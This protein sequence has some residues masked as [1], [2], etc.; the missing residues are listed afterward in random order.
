MELARELAGICDTLLKHHSSTDPDALDPDALETN[1]TMGAVKI[2]ELKEAHFGM[3]QATEELK[4]STTEAMN[5]LDESSLH[6]ENLL[7][8]KSHYERE[9]Q[10]CK[11]YK[12]AYTDEQLEL[13]AAEEYAAR[14]A[15][16][17]AKTL[18]LSED[19]HTAMLARLEEE[20][21]Y[22]EQ[23]LRDLEALKVKRDALAAQLA[24]RRDAI[25]GLQSDIANLRS[26]AQQMQQKY[27][28]VSNSI[29]KLPGPLYMLYS[30][31]AAMAALLDLP[32]T[33]SIVDSSRD[34]GE[35]PPGISTGQSHPCAVKFSFLLKTPGDP[36]DRGVDDNAMVEDGENSKEPFVIILRYFPHAHTVTINAKDE[37]H[38]HVL[39]QLFEKD[40]SLAE[41]GDSVNEWVVNNLLSLHLFP[42]P[43]PSLDPL[44]LDSIPCGPG[45]SLGAE[46]SLQTCLNILSF[47]QKLMS[48]I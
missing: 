4:Q 48:A 23:V 36:E 22:R 37:C 47:L 17:D 3:C 1:C 40:R 19:P 12:S 41:K 13:L 38:D 35:H 44:P 33:I 15:D 26:S 32:V 30:N 20:L 18:I 31:S 43:D 24:Q 10:A 27:E 34:H 11:S 8:E 14:T 29:A 16:M 5:R 7:Y 45:T 42:R 21:K 28:S 9:I 46:R 2:L 39:K 6:L 25:T